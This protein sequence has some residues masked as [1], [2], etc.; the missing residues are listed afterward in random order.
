MDSIVCRFCDIQ[1]YSN[2]NC[3]RHELRVHQKEMKEME[4]NDSDHSS[5]TGSQDS[6]D[7]QD[8]RKDI[9]DE[10]DDTESEKSSESGEHYWSELITEICR[11]IE[12]KN[13]I[14]Y[15]KEVLFE[16]ML[17]RFLEE[18]RDNLDS[19]M[20]FA[21]YMKNHDKVYQEIQNTAERY[22][23]KELEEDEAFEKAWNDRKYLLKRML[24]DNLDVIEKTL[25]ESSDHSE[26][27]EEEEDQENYGPMMV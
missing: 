9:L 7:T 25:D 21:D 23:R 12:L 2:F 10:Q 18:L 19:R 8:R 1:F 22:E 27:E 15:P 26:E 17:S 3:R 14:K 13:E 6:S 16:P 5:S 4:D 24:R 20:K 11:E